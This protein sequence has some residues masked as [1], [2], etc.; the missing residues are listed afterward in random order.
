MPFRNGQTLSKQK[1]G[2]CFPKF[3]LFSS[4]LFTFCCLEASASSP[5]QGDSSVRSCAGPCPV[6]CT[7]VIALGSSVSCVVNCTNIGLERGP[8]ATDLPPGTNVLDLSRN[9][10]S[11]LETS[12]FDQLTVLRELDLS[13]NLISTIEESIRDHLSNLTEI[14]LSRNQFLCDCKL[15]WLVSWL[16]EGGVRVRH[17]ETMLCYQPPDLRFQPLLNISLLTCG[18]T[19]A[20]CLEI[21]PSGGDK[22]LVIFSSST[23]GNFSRKECNSVCYGASQL[24][25]GLGA[26]R[27]CLCSTNDEPNRLSG[28]PCSAFCTKPNVM[29]ECHLTL[30][31]DVFAVDFTTSLLAPPPVSVHS[32]AHLSV[33]SSVMPVTLSWDF[34]DRSPRL[35]ASETSDLT[36]RH[37]YALPG[38]YTVVVTAWAGNK[39]VHARGEQRVTL[40]PLLELRC[41]SLVV[42]NQSLAVGLINWGGVS[43]AV[44]WRITNNDGQEAARATPACPS[45]AVF[46]AES[47]R[48][49]QMVPEVFSWAEARRQCLSTGGDLAVVRSDPLR[50]KLAEKV[51]Q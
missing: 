8:T 18:V 17:P 12:L 36:T 22:E 48:C 39:E 40:P 34:G 51:K 35:N 2:A 30:A 15:S 16:Q 38:N 4:L 11:S 45:D 5:E 21:L 25:G 24:Y 31:H 46:D 42:A 49:F 7:C 43:V 50:S 10:I 23:P 27:E 29:K 33:M 47:R 26:R 44:D 3:G 9:R 28:S 6:N 14:D 1:H 32:P 37:K 13:H 20:A 41:P 19:Y